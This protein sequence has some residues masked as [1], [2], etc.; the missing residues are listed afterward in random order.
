MF[1]VDGNAHFNRPGPRLLDAAEFLLGVLHERWELIPKGFEF[2]LL[3]LT[4]GDGDGDGDAQG[5]DNGDSAQQ[6]CGVLAHAAPPF[7]VCAV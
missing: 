7:P 3:Q 1:L 4:A 6:R 5:G 2:E